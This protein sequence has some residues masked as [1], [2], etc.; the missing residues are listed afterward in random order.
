MLVA[1][2]V[3]TL[4]ERFSMESD[5]RFRHSQIAIDIQKFSSFWTARRPQYHYKDRLYLGTSQLLDLQSGTFSFSLQNHRRG[6]SS[7]V[8]MVLPGIL[9]ASKDRQNGRHPP[10]RLQ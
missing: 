4:P 1:F 10:I 7:A 2:P 3:Q 8:G 6:I 5:R 9:T